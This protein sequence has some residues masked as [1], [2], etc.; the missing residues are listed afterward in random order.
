MDLDAVLAALSRKQIYSIVEADAAINL[1]EGSVRSGKTIA[2]IVRWLLFLQDPP[3]DG[4]LVMIGKTRDTVYRNVIEPMTKVSLFGEVAK[5]VE[6]TPGAQTAMILGRRV[7]IIGAN[8]AKSEPKIRGMTV[9]GAYVDETTILPKTFFDQLVA[10]CSVEGARIF[11]TTNPDNPSHWLRKEYML[12]ADAVELRSWH[13]GLADNPYL[14][15]AYVER[16]K[17]TYTGLWYRRFVLGEWVLAEGSV[18]EAWDPARHVVNTLPRIDTWLGVGLDYGASNPFAALAGGVGTG[19]DGVRRVYLTHEYRHD[20]RAARRQLAASEYSQELRDWLASAEL[21]GETAVD[22]TAALGLRPPWIYIDPASDFGNQLFYDGVTNYANAVNAVVPG[23]QTMSSLIASD[24]LRVATVCKGF[25]DEV[26]GYSWD[27]A[28]AQRGED[29][30]IKVDD[31]SLDAAR[32][33]VHS[34]EHTWRRDVYAL[35]V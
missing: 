28:A 14:P 7:H 19:P 27:D 1:W 5:Q 2:S 22:G 9:A 32:Y 4:E 8:D 30:P 11:A 15:A 21:P 23:I 13:F 34:T 25:I 35:A 24:R 31:H 26:A 16:L 3:A 33:L 17:R 20:S 18:Y 10:R 29:R 6:Y 12:R